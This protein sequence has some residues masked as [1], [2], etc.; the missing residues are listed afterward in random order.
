L[1]TEA[2]R[3]DETVVLSGLTGE[4][5]EGLVHLIDEILG[6]KDQGF[7]LLVPFSDGA[8][9]AWLHANAKIVSEKPEDGGMRYDVVVDPVSWAKFNKDNRY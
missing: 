1:V 4:G 7:D 6:Q 2:G 8:T 5:C 3:L 9:Q